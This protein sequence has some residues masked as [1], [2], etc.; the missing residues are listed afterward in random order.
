[1]LAI[2]RE[3][4]MGRRNRAERLFAG[5]STDHGCERDRARRKRA[6]MMVERL[7]SARSEGVVDLG[8]LVARHATL[9]QIA[10]PGVMRLHTSVERI[11]VPDWS[12]RLL[13]VALSEL[14]HAAGTAAL[15]PCGAALYLAVGWSGGQLVVALAVRHPDCAPVLTGSGADA[16]MRADRVARA[17]GGGLV[18]GMERDGMLFG[19]TFEWPSADPGDWIPF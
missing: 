5:P 4:R 12:A 19:L 1:M 13:L 3:A 14:I 10:T 17:M 18:R 16:F 2:L 6:R 11:L 7:L 15:T 9:E 8:C